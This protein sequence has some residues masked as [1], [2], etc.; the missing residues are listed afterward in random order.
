MNMQ[1]KYSCNDHEQE[2]SSNIVVKH[3]KLTLWQKNLSTVEMQK[4]LRKKKSSEELENHDNI[5]H[6][7]LSSSSFNAVFSRRQAPNSRN[8]SENS[9]NT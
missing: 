9:E 6:L 7:P 1:H 8:D 5:F 2:A 3:I 4:I